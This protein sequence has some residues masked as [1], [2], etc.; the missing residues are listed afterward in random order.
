MPHT[1][2]ARDVLK[3][4]SALS[5]RISWRGMILPTK[6]GIPSNRVNNAKEMHPLL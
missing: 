5:D 3:V 6:H 2:T 4:L 1:N